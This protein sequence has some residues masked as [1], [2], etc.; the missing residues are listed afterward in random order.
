MIR[1]AST[2]DA[3]AI[4]D[5]HAQSWTETYPGLVPEVLLAEM[6]DPAGRRAA[7]ARNLAAPLLPGSTLVAE[8]AG[9]ILGFISVCAARDPALG[10]GGEVSGLYLLRRAQGRGLGRA[11]LAAGAEVLLRAGHADAGAWALDKNLRARAF[12]AATGAIPRTSQIGWHGDVAIAE[13]AWVWADLH[14][15]T[16][17]PG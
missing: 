6:T 11:L 8:E 15:V 2:A 5:M 7:W 14:G 12:Y 4:G 1:P 16:R 13:T 10:A 9:A 3:P 17:R